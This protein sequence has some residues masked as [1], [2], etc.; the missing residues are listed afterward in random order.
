MGDWFN[1]FRIRLT[2]LFGGLSLVLGIG[3]TLYINHVASA[4]ITKANGEL[5][6]GTASSIANALAENFREREREIMLLSHHPLLVQG[7]LDSPEVRRGLEQVA[8]SYRNYAWLGVADTSGIVQAAAD[9]VLEGA[10]VSQ[11]PWFT[12]GLRG[13]YISDVHEAVLL[14]KR[15]QN[16]HPGEPLRFVDFASPV[17][18]SQGRLRGVLA[19]H[20]HWTWAGE[21]I[22]AALPR[23]ARQ[24]GI[25]AF[26]VN[27]QGEILY[28][29][30][31]SGQSSVPPD[32]SGDE[33]Y[34][35]VDWGGQGTFLTGS[36]GV[37][38]SSGA[39]PDLGWRVIVRQPA[40]RA[41]AP[42][43]ELHRNLLFLGA[44]V[45]ALFM[46]LTYRLAS[47]FSRPIEELADAASRVQG[48]GEANPIMV[49]SGIRE[50]RKLTEALRE[51]TSTLLRRKRELQEIN[52]TLENRIEERTTQLE[53]SNKQLQAFTYAASHDLKAP[54]ARIGSFSTLLERN[55]RD[56]LD[57]D[58]LLF[59]DFI[60]S[61]TVRMASLIEDM[62]AHAQI[63]QQ[64]SNL[65][66][67][68]IGAAIRTI[69]SERQS[70][71]QE[72]GTEV[73]LAL[74][75]LEVRADPMALGQVLRNLVDN[76]LKYSARSRP[77]VVEIGG[78]AIDGKCRLWVRDNGV[79]FDMAQHD[80]IFEI[81]RRLHSYEE[82]PGSGVGLALVKRAME[83]MDGRVWAE[84]DGPGTGATF[85][86]ELQRWNPGKGE[87]KG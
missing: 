66:S 58:A 83:R 40:A 29:H 7:R 67:L 22:K 8:R 64:A 20:A 27:R 45:T 21:V 19:S 13:S 53:A 41:L 65:Q 86:L 46:A 63:E 73:R 62:L 32:L 1:S 87:G 39:N 55:Y 34:A 36:M 17:R 79:G 74:P 50:T 75:E 54:L 4:H 84:S 38:L 80:R 44:L 9:G 25:E 69:V 70:E 23:D 10:D 77:P 72:S 57:G 42:V 14:A 82:F 43:A 68:D 3:V 35:L 37:H 15:L 71:I 30:Q 60:R 31:K 28:P 81:F 59:L 51:M 61:N 18:D 24:E 78:E 47:A 12:R 16:P 76:A 52:S 26:I 33:A 2:L 85:Y 48:D 6:Q 49:Q 5:L 56:R 11:R